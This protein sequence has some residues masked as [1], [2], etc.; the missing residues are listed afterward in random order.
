M[1]DRCQM[2]VK[3]TDPQTIDHVLSLLGPLKRPRRSFDLCPDRHSYG[4]E[5]H[6]N[7]SPKQRIGG[8]AALLDCYVGLYEHYTE[9]TTAI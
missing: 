1:K 7:Q 4:T 9:Y 8:T 5:S 2:G 6:K 3:F